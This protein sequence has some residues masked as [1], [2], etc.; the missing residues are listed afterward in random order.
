MVAAGAPLRA[1][2]EWMGHSDYRT[3]TIYADY[4]LDS[5]Q[6]ARYAAIA[7]DFSPAPNTDAVLHAQLS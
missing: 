3:T 2:Q 7:F 6:G 1:V 4:A 5:T